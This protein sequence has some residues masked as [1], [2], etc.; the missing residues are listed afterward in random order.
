MSFL[1]KLDKGWY[2]LVALLLF[3]IGRFAYQMSQ[4]RA[5][6]ELTPAQKRALEQRMNNN[7]GSVT[8]FN[9]SRSALFSKNPNENN[10]TGSEDLKKKP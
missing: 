3:F 7:S 4:G 10:A 6:N 9:S 5:F 8:I 2:I 1:K